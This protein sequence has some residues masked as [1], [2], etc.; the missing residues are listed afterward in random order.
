MSLRWPTRCTDGLSEASAAA[1]EGGYLL[2]SN[3]TLLALVLDQWPCPSCR[4]AIAVGMVRRY[5][6]GRDII[7]EGGG[8][9][10][11]IAHGRETQRATVPMF[12][13]KDLDWGRSAQGGAPRLG[14]CANVSALLRQGRGTAGGSETQTKRQQ[15]Q[16]RASIASEGG[17]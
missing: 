11:G 14:H 4:R 17:R 9:R 7:L 10:T 6:A 12:V 8:E 5:D 1:A 13:R 16:Q 15:E 3:D 2:P